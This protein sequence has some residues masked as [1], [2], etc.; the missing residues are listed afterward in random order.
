ML[1]K[2]PDPETATLESLDGPSKTSQPIKIKGPVKDVARLSKNSKVFL[3][4]LGVAVVIGIVVGTTTAGHKNKNSATQGNTG[5][6]TE[7]IGVTPIDPD[8]FKSRTTTHSDNI[9]PAAPTTNNGPLA[10]R[11][12]PPTDATAAASVAQQQSAQ[13]PKQQYLKWLSEQHYKQIEGRILAADAAAL[14]EPNTKGLATTESGFGTTNNSNITSTGASR[15]RDAQDAALKEIQNNPNLT[16]EQIQ[17][18]LKDLPTGDGTGQAANKQ[19]VAEQQTKNDGYLDAAETPKADNHELFAGS[20]IPAILLSGIDSDLP[21]VMSAMVRQTIYDSL[22]PNIVLI[23]QGTKL[24]G[25]YSAGVAYGQTRVLAAWTRLI[26]PNGSTIDL[27]GMLG[28]DEQ[29]L[30]GFND[31][32]DNHFMK[33]FG[34][35]ILISLLGVGAEL[36]QPQNSGALNTPPASTA[37][38]SAL[39]TSLDQ[40]GTTLLNK[41]LQIQPTLNIRQGYTFNVMVNRTMIMPPY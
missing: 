22:N 31:Q 41:N 16:K 6:S 3:S 10:A 26:F 9:S 24:I 11:G 13:Q 19:F 32:V 8:I 5:S 21:G 34:S 25:E 30:S 7:A 29:G 1:D 28:A 20:V 17:K 23:P 2:H 37:A 36:S 4:A 35:S 12:T 39:A 14:A 33:I 38:A 27:K 40:T 18:L 15:L